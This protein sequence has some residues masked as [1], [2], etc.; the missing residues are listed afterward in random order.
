MTPRNSPRAN[1]DN[2]TIPEVIP[3]I[4]TLFAWITPLLMPSSTRKTID[5]KALARSGRTLCVCIALTL[6]GCQTQGNHPVDPQ[7]DSDR[8]AL[9]HPINWSETAKPELPT[10]VWQR[11]RSGYQLQDE[12]GINPRVERQRL[13]FAS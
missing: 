1:Q 12:I 4:A 9:K 3:R 6:A 13:W 10:D 5:P 2:L 8:L 11:I 7:A